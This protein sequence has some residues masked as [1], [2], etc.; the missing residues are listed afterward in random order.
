[1]QELKVINVP[2]IFLY[3][4]FN[5]DGPE[6][7]KIFVVQ[8]IIH[9]FG[10]PGRVLVVNLFGKKIFRVKDLAFGFYFFLI[11]KGTLHFVRLIEL[12]ISKIIKQSH[13]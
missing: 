5:E 12:L 10:K 4:F 9:K 8:E 2:I 1:M 11:E 6:K 7:V 3:F 13:S